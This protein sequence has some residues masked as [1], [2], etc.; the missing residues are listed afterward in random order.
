MEGEEFS[1]FKQQV[2]GEIAR[3]EA[4]MITLKKHFEQQS[5]LIGTL[6]ARVHTLERKQ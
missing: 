1:Q 5:F 2:F 4:I 3:L 6:T